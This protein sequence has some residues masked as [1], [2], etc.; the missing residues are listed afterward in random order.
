MILDDSAEPVYEGPAAEFFM[1]PYRK[2]CSA[3]GLDRSLFEA[4]FQQRNACYFP[5]PFQKRCRI[6][7]KGDLQKIHFYQIQIRCYQSGTKVETFAPGDLKRYRR[8]FESTAH[9][10]ANLQNWACQ[11]QV[12]LAPLHK[13]IAAGRT[14]ELLA[15]EG[16][17]A[18]EQLTLKVTAETSL[19]LLRESTRMNQ[20]HFRSRPMVR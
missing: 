10:L 19:A 13:E 11:S 14:A 7:W 18:I 1:H 16:P 20:Y 4:T 12:E 3:A 5:I 2:F 15:L 8:T 9:I 17:R 6:T